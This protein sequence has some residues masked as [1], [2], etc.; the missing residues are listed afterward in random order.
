MAL[1]LAVIGTGIMGKNAVQVWQR[2]QGVEVVA[3]CDKDQ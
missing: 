3:V 1:R 2:H